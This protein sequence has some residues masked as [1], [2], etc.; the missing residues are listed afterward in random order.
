MIKD[1][2]I[3]VEAVYCDECGKD[4]QSYNGHPYHIEDNKH[5]CLNCAYK[6][7]Q[8]SKREWC[9]LNGIGL[10]DRAIRNLEIVTDEG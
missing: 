8:I 5:F 2:Q 9:N 6:L 4:V 10:S 1:I 7:K 3:T